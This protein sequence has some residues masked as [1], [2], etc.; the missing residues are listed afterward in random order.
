MNRDKHGTF[1]FQNI[2]SKASPA[3]LLKKCS[4][5]EQ[6]HLNVLTSLLYDF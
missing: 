4:S 2:I 5:I 3:G 1:E 6:A